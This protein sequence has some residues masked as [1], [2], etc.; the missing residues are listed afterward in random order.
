MS[1]SRTPTP[2][3]PSQTV[4]FPEDDITNR[5]LY[6]FL[7]IHP[8]LTHLD[9]SP[10]SCVLLSPA[11]SSTALIS[12]GGDGHQPA[13]AGYLGRGML[14]AVVSGSVFASP[15]SASILACLQSVQAPA[16]L[17]VVKNY[18]GDRL[19]FALAL[20]QHLSSPSPSSR[21]A[22]V[23]MVVVGDDVAVPRGQ[24]VAGRRGLAGTILVHK[25]AGA[26]ASEGADLP[27]TAA[28]ARDVARRLCTV[29]V[30]FTGCGRG[31]ERLAAGE[32][33]VGM[34]IHGEPGIRRCATKPIDAVVA[35]LLDLLLSRDPSHDFFHREAADPDPGILFPDVVLLVNNLHGMMAHEMNL[36][37]QLARGGLWT[38]GVEVER[39][40]VGS[41]M[42]AWSMR[43]F[44]LTLLRLPSNDT[45]RQAMLS[46]LDAPTDAP[47]WP[48]V[49]RTAPQPPVPVPAPRPA[50]PATS[51][52]PSHPSAFSMRDPTSVAVREAL[53]AVAEALVGGEAELN[54]LDALAGD[55]D[56]GT[57]FARA[58]RAL[59][60][61]LSTQPPESAPVL[62]LTPLRSLLSSLSPIAEAMGG[63]SG[64]LYSLLLL[65]AAR[66]ADSMPP[67][68][69][70]MKGAEA[71]REYGGAWLGDRTMLDA[72]VPA[73]SAYD[74]EGWPGALQAAKAGMLSTRGMKA[75]AGRASYVSADALSEADAGAMAVRL[76]VEALS[77]S[78]HTAA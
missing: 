8:P 51:S 41:L 78:L 22:A 43:G 63:T 70:L 75:R 69:A 2:S 7:T 60:S 50:P 19:N 14:S 73:L 66:H 9:T 62:T 21:C 58:A 72:L 31:E 12:G 68:E 42:T 55:G 64:A 65:T 3:T 18:T 36:I 38:R 39:A 6:A 53:R 33:E 40:V 52:R 17:L 5:S 20:T 46:R 48:A 13:H 56:C 44:S 11:P 28:I 71:V 27:T 32:M 61:A 34:G 15:S 23:E 59:L 67:A 26:A 54:R 1:A 30:A 4:V 49:S 37:A 24:S 57:T 45:A 35:D 47:A 76:I 16:A 25:I 29:G 74:S 77:A 10:H